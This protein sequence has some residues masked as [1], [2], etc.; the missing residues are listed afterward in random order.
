M[1]AIKQHLDFLR[2]NI[3]QVEK[4]WPHFAGML[5]DVVALTKE[6][7][8]EQQ[9]VILERSYVYG[10]DSL[11]A[12]LFDKGNVVSVDCQTLTAGE[13][14]GYQ[15]SWTNDPRCIHITSQYKEPITDTKL[16]AASADFLLIPNV[17][18][19]V[20]DQ[21]AMFKEFA[22]LLKPGGVGYIFEALLRELHQI[23]DDFIRYTPW[24]F[25]YM[26]EKVG[27]KLVKHTPVGGPFEAIAYCWVQALQYFPEEIRKEKEEWF[28]N[29]HFKEL[30]HWDQT[31]TEN[32]FR[33][34]T[35]FPIGY[36]IYF[37][38]Q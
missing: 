24:G 22:R 27:L 10:G 12:P 18:H 26:L 25:E 15:S 30:M 6:V 20:R 1:D 16:A 14:G 37:T 29:Q 4:K 33:K 31:Y 34:H 19:H 17:I 21:D 7:K 38:K 9:V 35:E 32:K 13:R 36:G 28:F 5:N 11:F 23:P 2:E 8:P 3:F